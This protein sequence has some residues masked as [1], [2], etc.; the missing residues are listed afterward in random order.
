MHRIFAFNQ[1]QWLNHILRSTQKK[2]QKKK[3]NNGKA[4]KV[5]YKLMDTA[6]Y[7]KTMEIESM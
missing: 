4:G 2:D 1:S 5:L 3:K 7:R 6:I